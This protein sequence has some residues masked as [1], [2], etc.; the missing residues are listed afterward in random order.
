MS[1]S[2]NGGRRVLREKPQGLSLDIERGGLELDAD[3]TIAG[4]R[5]RPGSRAL[6]SRASSSQSVRSSFGIGSNQKRI[7]PVNDSKIQI[8]RDGFD[9]EE[10]YYEICEPK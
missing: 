4:N 2:K 8:L 6:S 5:N 7:M 10:V 1:K 9:D 3:D